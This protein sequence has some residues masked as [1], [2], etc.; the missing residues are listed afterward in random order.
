MQAIVRKFDP[1]NGVAAK[2]GLGHFCYVWSSLQTPK[3]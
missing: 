1:Q 2:D 3:I